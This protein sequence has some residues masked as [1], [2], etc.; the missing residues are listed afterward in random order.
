LVLTEVKKS[1]EDAKAGGTSEKNK[2]GD[3]GRKMVS[4][5]RK[6]RDE[7]VAP[8]DLIDTLDSSYKKRGVGD[9]KKQ[10][11]A[12]IQV[13]SLTTANDSFIGLGMAEAG[14]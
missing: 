10:K 14:I 11:G 6:S 9:G 5:K 2:S 4:W 1:L 7:E 12:A 8:C 13:L 3:H